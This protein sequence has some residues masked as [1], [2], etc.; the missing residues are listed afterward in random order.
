MGH[1]SAWTVRG[2]QFGKQQAALAEEQAK[3]GVSKRGGQQQ[4]TV[5]P[6]HVGFA[7]RPLEQLEGAQPDPARHHSSFTY[8]HDLGTLPP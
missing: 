5:Q 3:A 8:C 2:E 6:P 1:G 4:L 7:W